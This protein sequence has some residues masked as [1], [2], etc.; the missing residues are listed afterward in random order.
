MCIKVI[1]IWEKG[2]VVMFGSALDRPSRV[3]VVGGLTESWEVR[4]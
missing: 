3:N 1:L 4:L 2:N